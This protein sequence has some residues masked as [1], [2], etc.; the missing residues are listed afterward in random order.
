LHYSRPHSA[1]RI[2]NEK[3]A[4]LDRAKPGFFSN[5][6]HEF[7]AP[8]TLILGPLEDALTQPEKSLRGENLE[9]VHHSALRRFGW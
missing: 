8:L 3:L 7:R 1:L 2:A 9:A 5:V 6:S 4:E